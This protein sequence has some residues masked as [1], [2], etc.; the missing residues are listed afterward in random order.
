[1]AT[2]Y[3]TKWVEAKHTKKNDAA[4][5][6]AFLFENIITRFGCPL[7]LVSDRG[8]HFLNDTI[9]LI[10]TKYL[11]KHRKTTPYNPRANGLIERAS[12]LMGKILN[13]LV[14]ADKTDWDAKL[15]SALWAYRTAEKIT[16]KRTPFY[17][18]YGLDS[19]IPVEFEVPT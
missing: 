11:I 5:T 6:A 15:P 1:M 3:L 4:T 14:S 19:I 16:T 18:T 10:T 13:K 9:E 12:G 7:E 2:D 17:L 8:L